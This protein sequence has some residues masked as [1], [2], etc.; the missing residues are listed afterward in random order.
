MYLNKSREVE[1]NL[2]PLYLK[3]KRLGK[4]HS[5]FKS[6]INIQFEDVLVYISYVGA[7]LSAFGINV[8][9]EK[10]LKII[11][12]VSID[13]TVVFKDNKLI[14]YSIYENTIVSLKNITKLNL[15]LPRIKCDKKQITTNA[16]YNFLEEYEFE[17]L[18]GIDLDDKTYEYVDLLLN[19]DKTNPDI[20]K[21]IIKFFIGRGKGLTPSGDDILIGF[22]MALMTFDNNGDLNNWIKDINIMMNENLTTIIS[23]SYLKALT[24]GY[25][26]EHFIELIKSMDCKENKIIYETVKKVQTFGHTSG[27]DT[28][29]GFFLGLKFLVKN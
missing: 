19:S 20:N 17:N 13:D 3:N 25:L 21:K 15:K 6:G 14:F 7:P 26:S 23:V 2:L 27:N 9:K 8:E 29:F 16:L 1:S 10:L 22:T 5:K 4:V 18:I 12:S 24:K 11:N 28:L